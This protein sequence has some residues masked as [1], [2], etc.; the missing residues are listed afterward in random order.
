ML[1]KRPRQNISLLV[2]QVEIRW[3]IWVGSLGRFTPKMVAPLGYL[4]RVS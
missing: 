4:P 3:V 1:K 2:E